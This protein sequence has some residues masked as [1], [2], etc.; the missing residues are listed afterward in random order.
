MTV[1]D[2]VTPENVASL[3]VGTIVRWTRDDGE[4]ACAIKIRPD[5][6]DVSGVPSDDEDDTFSDD[7]IAESD[8]APPAFI[9]YL[10]EGA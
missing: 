8:G 7:F 2:L 9:A 6:W 10:P 3:P 5:A 4:P 1:G